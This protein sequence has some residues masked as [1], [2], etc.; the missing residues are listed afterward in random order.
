MFRGF[1]HS[2][3]L[4]LG[5]PRSSVSTWSRNTKKKSATI[6]VNSHHMWI[7]K[8]IQEMS[9]SR[10]NAPLP[11]V[12]GPSSS[13]VGLGGF[14]WFVGFFTPGTWPLGVP[15]FLWGPDVIG[16]AS[17]DVGSSGFDGCFFGVFTTGTWPLGVPIAAFSPGQRIQKNKSLTMNAITHGRSTQQMSVSPTNAPLFL[18]A[19]DVDGRAPLDMLGSSDFDGCF[20]GVITTGTCWLATTS[21]V[22]QN[23]KH[24]RAKNNCVILSKASCCYASE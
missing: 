12:D 22:Q 13:N 10:T 17:S 4:A 3:N 11:D 21:P 1:F 20:F 19:P 8:Q 2:W 9:V 14:G 5:G 18:L 23:R 15:F 7:N 6:S 16:R 24:G